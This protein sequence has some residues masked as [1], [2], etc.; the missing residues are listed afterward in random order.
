MDASLKD[1]KAVP[2][3][4]SVTSGPFHL[5]SW[6][7][8]RSW[9]LERNPYYWGPK[10]SVDEIQYTLY[11]NQEGLVQA[12]RNGEV[13]AIDNF[14][15]SLLATMQNTPHVTVQKSVSDWW[16]NLAFNFGGQGPGADPLP[17][18]HDLQLRKAIE[19]AIDKKAIAEKVYQG[20]ATPGDTIVRPASTFWHLDIPSAQEFPYSPSDANALLDEAGY[21]DT[22]GD[23]VRE[24]PKTGDPL[25]LRMPVATDTE[26]ALEA[27]QLIVGYLKAIGIDVGLL[28]SSDAKMNDYW[29]T[30]NFDAYIWYWSGDPDP[31]YQLSVFTSGQCGGWS[32]GCWKDPHFDQL[33]EEQRTT[34]DQTARLKL[35]QEAQRY[36]YEQ[37]PS[38]VLAYPN[39]LSAY[40]NDRYRGWVPAPRHG[41]L[42]PVYNY[43]SLTHIQPVSAGIGEVGSGSSGLPAWLWVVALAVLGLVGVRL[44]RGRRATSDD[45]A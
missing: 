3:M 32:D 37:V 43:D 40:R 18:L 21:K 6:S 28:P 31:N 41:Y 12:L 2:N 44:V 15:P 24:D 45:K 22:D 17:A 34:M 35:V 16:L 23:G 36:Q 13:D 9:T 29:A 19:M 5:V 4:P 26:G 20:T 27:G 10:P 33:Y 38:V 42:I 7:Q 11:T 30:G 8:G 1:V 14:E 25:R 39:S